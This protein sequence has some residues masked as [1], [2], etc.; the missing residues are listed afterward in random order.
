[1]AETTLR[2][3]EEISSLAPPVSSSPVSDSC[4]TFEQVNLSR[5]LFAELLV[6]AIHPT[7]RV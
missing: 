5:T 7:M 4:M 6:R 2:L 3:L 1:M